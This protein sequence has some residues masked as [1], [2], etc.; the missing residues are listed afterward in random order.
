MLWEHFLGDSSSPRGFSGAVQ[1]VH[2]SRGNTPLRG[3]PRLTAGT[4]VYCSSIVVLSGAFNNPQHEYSAFWHGDSR[5]F[6]DRDQR[7]S[8]G[9][10]IRIWS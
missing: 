4:L 10:V 8:L 3:R 6:C 2:H 7:R 5:G 1:N 9:N